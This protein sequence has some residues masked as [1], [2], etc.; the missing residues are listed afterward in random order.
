[1]QNTIIFF[2]AF[3]LSIVLLS[4]FLGGGITSYQQSCV[5]PAFASDQGWKKC[6][7]VLYWIETGFS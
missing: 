7:T 4:V 1:M 6:S 2:R 3:I 5:G